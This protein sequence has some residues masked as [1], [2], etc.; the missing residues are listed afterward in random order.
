[1]KNASFYTVSLRKV[2]TG[3]KVTA[4]MMESLD[5]ARAIAVTLVNSTNYNRCF[6]SCLDWQGE[7]CFAIYP[8]SAEQVP[9]PQVPQQLQ[10]YAQPVQHQYQQLPQHHQAEAQARAQAQAYYDA[11]QYQAQQAAYQAQQHPSQQAYYAQEQE[12]PAKLYAPPAQVIRAL[13]AAAESVSN[14]LA[15]VLSHLKR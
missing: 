5:D 9:P 3:H 11:Q 10:G 14:K 7:Q 15:T 1:M 4:F 6:A 13:P 2:S 12:Q 8:Q